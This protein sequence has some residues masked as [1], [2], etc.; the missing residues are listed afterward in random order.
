M[1]EKLSAG[2]CWTRHFRDGVPQKLSG[3][4]PGFLYR[5]AFCRKNC[6]WPTS[7]GAKI[8]RGL[9]RLFA[10]IPCGSRT[11]KVGDL[12]V[13]GEILMAGYLNRHQETRSAMNGE[14]VKR[15]EGIFPTSSAITT[16]PAALMTASRSAASESCR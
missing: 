7:G 9:H 4:I 5:W 12:I 13:W 11:Y 6:P 8:V 10:L 3:R 1:P 15:C 14:S 2:P 16:L